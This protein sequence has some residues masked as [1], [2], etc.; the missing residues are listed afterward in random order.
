MDPPERVRDLHAPS[1]RP[2]HEHLVLAV[3]SQHIRAGDTLVDGELIR[4]L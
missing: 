2:R 1:P 4:K 3:H